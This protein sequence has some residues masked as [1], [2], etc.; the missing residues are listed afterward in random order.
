MEHFLIKQYNQV[1]N[2]LINLLFMSTLK[3]FLNN[4]LILFFKENT[5][6]YYLFLLILTLKQYYNKNNALILR[7]QFVAMLSTMK[8]NDYFHLYII[9]NIFP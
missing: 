8:C 6:N 7:N 4:S 2:N 9:Y 3:I 1:P 5:K